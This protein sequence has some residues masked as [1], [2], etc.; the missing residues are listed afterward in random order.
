MI[1]MIKIVYYESVKTTIHVTNLA[2]ILTNI[3]M[4]Y[5]SIPEFIISNNHILFMLK[6]LLSLC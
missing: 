1:K 4:K 3:F 5:Y 6:F 2:K